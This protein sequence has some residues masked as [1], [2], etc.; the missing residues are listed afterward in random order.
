MK[1]QREQFLLSYFKVQSFDL[2]RV[3]T[4]D[5]PHCSFMLERAEPPVCSLLVLGFV[6]VLDV[7][8][9]LYYVFI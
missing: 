3:R 1:L 5:L 4:L 9:A 7:I 2:A 6:L 8:L